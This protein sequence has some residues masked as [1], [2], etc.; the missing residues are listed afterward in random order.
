MDSGV[1]ET[2]T[3]QEVVEHGRNGLLVDF[4]DHAALADTLADAL[5]RRAALHPM[6][7]AARQTVVERYDLQRVCLPAMRGFA[8]GSVA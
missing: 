4:F 5:E 7:E 8:T 6:R 3:V 1:Q 2:L